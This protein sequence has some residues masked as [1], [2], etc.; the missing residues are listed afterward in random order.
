MNVNGI[1]TVW[2]NS[3]RAA[4]VRTI[5]VTSGAARRKAFMTSI[6]RDA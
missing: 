2:S 5:A 6:S 3:H 4:D 1:R